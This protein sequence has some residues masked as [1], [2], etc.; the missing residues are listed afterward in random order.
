MFPFGRQAAHRAKVSSLIVR[1][2]ATALASICQSHRRP[3]ISLCSIRATRCGP[4]YSYDS[5]TR[6]KLEAKDHMRA[7]GVK[8]PDEWDAVALTF[9]E[10]V[11]PD[12]GFG[13]RLEYPRSGVA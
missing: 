1:S 12:A 5:N 7:R 10:P 6:L 2:A 9:A 11:A 4:T 8:S 3:R 13:R